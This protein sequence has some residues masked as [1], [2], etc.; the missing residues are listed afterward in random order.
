MKHAGVKKY[1]VPKIERPSIHRSLC[2]ICTIFFLVK[3]ALYSVDVNGKWTLHNRRIFLRVGFRRLVLTSEM[4]KTISWSLTPGRG[5]HLLTRV[6]LLVKNKTR[7]LSSLVGKS[8]IWLIQKAAVERDSMLV[9]NNGF[10]GPID[11]W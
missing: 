3:V 7:V 11:V 1:R 2:Q 10:R 9:A 4:I 6:G 5:M 8:T